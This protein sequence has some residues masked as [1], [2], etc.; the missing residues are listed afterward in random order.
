MMTYSP[1]AAVA[2]VSPEESQ[3]P[4]I[5]KTSAATNRIPGISRKIIEQGYICRCRSAEPKEQ[6]DGGCKYCK[7]YAVS[8][9]RLH[10][11]NSRIRYLITNKVFDTNIE[12]SRS[13]NNNQMCAVVRC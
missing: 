3:A 9:V 10:C 2:H 12:E 4:M 8:D 6:A 5:I 7:E 1:L 13:G 11:S